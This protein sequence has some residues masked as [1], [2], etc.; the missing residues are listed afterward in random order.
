MTDSTFLTGRKKSTTET[1]KMEGGNFISD[2]DEGIEDT[3]SVCLQMVLNC[4]GV[5][6]LVQGRKALAKGSGEAGLIS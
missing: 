1:T 4:A 6:I 5:L 3:S 2:M